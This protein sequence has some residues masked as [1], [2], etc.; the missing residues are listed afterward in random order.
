MH[1]PFNNKREA[2]GLCQSKSRSSRHRLLVNHVLSLLV[3]RCCALLGGVASVSNRVIAPKLERQQKKLKE[4]GGG[5]YNRFPFLPISSLFIPGV[6]FPLIPTFS[7]NS[8]GNACYA[9]YMAI[10]FSFF[11]SFFYFFSHN[12]VEGCGTLQSNLHLAATLGE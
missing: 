3:A 6:F 11:I 2:S 10:R 5:G 9:G 4:G 12:F 8:R 7:T 1:F